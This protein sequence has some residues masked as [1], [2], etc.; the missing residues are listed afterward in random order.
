VPGLAFVFDGTLFGSAD[1]ID[2]FDTDA[3]ISI[4]PTTGVGALIGS[5]GSI[6]GNTVLGIDALAVHPATKILYG[7]SGHQFDGSPGDI[8]TIDKLTGT[9]TLIGTLSEFGTGS[10]LPATLAGLT[11]SPNGS[12]FGSLGG[13][14]AG[15]PGDGRI[16]SVDLTSFTFKFLGDAAPGSV[17]D[18]AVSPVPEPASITLLVIALGPLVCYWRRTRT[19]EVSTCP[20]RN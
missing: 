8:F 13:V 20:A 12:L 9:A 15:G 14:P 17:S 11:F 3:L 6:G 7:G 16:I 18:I 4:D 1:T 2:G 10:A 19:R 5:F